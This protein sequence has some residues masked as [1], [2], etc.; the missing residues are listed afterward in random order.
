MYKGIQRKTRKIEHYVA[1]KEHEMLTTREEIISG[2]IRKQLEFTTTKFE[3]EPNIK[4][5]DFEISNLIAAGIDPL[6]MNP[7][8]LSP[9]IEKIQKAAEQAGKTMEMAEIVMQ[10]ENEKP[11]QTQQNNE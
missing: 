8:S 7:T 3:P 6:Q 1:K 9:N 11:T 2:V 4:F 5:T 10:L